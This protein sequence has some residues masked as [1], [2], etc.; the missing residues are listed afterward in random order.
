MVHN[1]LKLVNTFRE[2][3]FHSNFHNQNRSIQLYF[4]RRKIKS[5][6]LHVQKNTSL[7]MKRCILLPMV[8]VVSELNLS[9]LN[10]YFSNPYFKNIF[11]SRRIDH[12]VDLGQYIW[13]DNCSNLLSEEKESRATSIR[14]SS[15][16]A[17]NFYKSCNNQLQSI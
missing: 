8:G 16:T 9:Y 3:G 10:D 15:T 12:L 17:R 14:A 5:T 13:C 6:I 2:E 11:A 4:L 1:L 7:L